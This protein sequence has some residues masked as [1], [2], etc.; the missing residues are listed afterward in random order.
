M[1]LQIQKEKKENERHFK[2]QCKCKVHRSLIGQIQSQFFFQ[3]KE[4]IEYYIQEI[5]S[6]GITNILPWTPPAS[7][8]LTGEDTPSQDS[9]LR[10]RSNSVHS[11]SSQSSLVLG[12]TAATMHEKTPVSEGINIHLSKK[13]YRCKS[14]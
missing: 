12:A 1:S 4:V 7:K 6:E 8:L 9:G 13:V 11:N 2:K 14:T 3:G 5:L 10:S